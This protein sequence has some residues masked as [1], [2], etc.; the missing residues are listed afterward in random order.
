MSVL[1]RPKDNKNLHLTEHA[2]QR[3]KQRG[4]SADE[5]MEV[6]KGARSEACVA[7]DG[8]VVTVYPKGETCV[9]H[10]RFW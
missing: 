3:L 4:Y 2:E 9:F 8:A 1:Y 6:I 10:G 7:P 5:R